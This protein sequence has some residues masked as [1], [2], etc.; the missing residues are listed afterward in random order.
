MARI[1][2]ETETQRTV[3]ALT[4]IH[5]TLPLPL[6]RGVIG[7]AVD[8]DVAGSPVGQK[9][10]TMLVHQL[11]RMKGI[12]PAVT[13]PPHFN[14][15]SIRPGTPLVGT[16]LREGL[17]QLVSSLNSAHSPHQAVLSDD[18]APDLVIA[19]GHDRG[20][21]YVG[22]G[23]WRAL[24]G[25]HAFDAGWNDEAP[26]GAYLAAS[27]AAAQALAQLVALNTG[28]PIGLPPDVA[29][30]L[31]DHTFGADANPGTDLTD[32]DLD[33]V[34]LTGA[35]AG[36]T[37]ALYTLAS[38]PRL[39]GN[40]NIVEPGYHKLSNLGR[41]LT[42]TFSDVDTGAHKLDTINRHL[43][44]YAP[45][46]NVVGIPE[47]W[48]DNRRNA[49][50][51]I[52]TVDTLE[53][54][55]AIQ[56]DARNVILEAG[57]DGYTYTVLRVVPG[58]RCICCKMPPDAVDRRAA[59]NWGVSIE[60]C[61]RRTAENAIIT[62]E[63]IA[64]LAQIQDKPAEEYVDLLHRPWNEAAPPLECGDARITPQQVGTIPMATTAA[65]IVIAAETAKHFA[66]V[67]TPLD[68]SFDH[69]LLHAPGPRNHKHRPT[70]TPCPYHGT[71]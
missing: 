52:A 18:A 10:T 13:I 37:A 1:E 35:G 31:F 56:R 21:I 65:G 12:I 43:R 3:K 61:R 69:N 54:R 6:P 49:D 59:A 34:I 7:I 70:T 32:L 62:R 63:D 40:M 5:G 25:K 39:G 24:T 30:S 33:D 22:A 28:T 71:R 51:V 23:A 55:F 42:V 2:S 4:Q 8:R 67:G 36:G 29:H 44:M 11:V 20:D 27:L 53:G 47:R 14:T 26:F 15:I 46:L 45:S 60:E 38:L 58:G 64:Q 16:S 9:L 41:Y 68:N 50:L 17:H 57:V 48:E 66:G 19:I